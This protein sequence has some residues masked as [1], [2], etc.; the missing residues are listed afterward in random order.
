MRD[1]L[2]RRATT[3]CTSHLHDDFQKFIYGFTDTL[4]VIKRQTSRRGKGGCTIGGLEKWFNIS[5]AG[6]HNAVA[7][8]DILQNIL[9]KAK[10]G[11]D[12]F[13]SAKTFEERTQKWEQNAESKI[14]L[15]TLNPLKKQQVK[16]FVR[17]SLTHLSLLTRL[18][19]HR[20]YLDRLV[21]ISSLVKRLMESH[22]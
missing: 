9:K 7:D 3:P 19:M 15:Q 10:I 5:S 2:C 21:S 17:K 6:S 4:T 12:L 18:K 11:Y 14:V 20:D 8:V 1:W 22:L 16:V 13:N